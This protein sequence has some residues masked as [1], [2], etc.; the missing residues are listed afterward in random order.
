[1]THFCKK[2]ISTNKYD[3]I[4]AIIGSSVINVVQN[5]V[6]CNKGIGANAIKDVFPMNGLFEGD[7]YTYYVL[8]DNGTKKL[9]NELN[10]FGLAQKCGNYSNKSS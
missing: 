3:H 4:I 9:I 6:I 2:S 10:Y 8:T 1:M 7:R 5:S